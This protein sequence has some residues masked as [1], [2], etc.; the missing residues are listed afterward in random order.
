[1]FSLMLSMVNVINDLRNVKVAV[2]KDLGRLIIDNEVMNVSRG[3]EV[4]LPKWLAT[5]LAK[6]NIVEFKYGPLT[7]DDVSK[8]LVTEKSLSKSAISKLRDDFYIE[9]RELLSRVKSSSLDADSAIIAIRLESNL[10]DLIKLRL[11]KILNIATLS[12]KVEKF[13]DNLTLEEQLLL[14]LLNE[15]ISTWL[16]LIT[17]EAVRVEQRG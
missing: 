7:I 10:R 5:V 14:K 6:L 12:V 16:N 2:L 4:E 13:E 11:N 8:Y 9:S 15:L 1:M 3:Q 17:V